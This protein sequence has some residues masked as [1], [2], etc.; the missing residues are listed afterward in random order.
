MIS[1]GTGWWRPKVND[2]ILGLNSLF[3]LVPEAG[4]A[5]L[6]L[7]TMIHDSQLNALQWLQSM[8]RYPQQKE[9]RWTIDGEVDDLLVEHNAPFLVN[10][11]PQLR[12]RRLDL[13]LEDKALEKLLGHSVEQECTALGLTPRTDDGYRNRLR[14]AGEAWE[15]STMTM[16]LREL[17]EFDR[18][19]LR[20]Q[21]EIGSRYAENAVD[22]DDFPREFDPPMMGGPDGSDTVGVIEPPTDGKPK[23]GLFG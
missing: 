11:E 19:A 13:R 4:R 21:F 3:R 18:D 16:R 10:N 12:F 15:Q 7:Q 5:I 2:K 6:I 9:K 8:S 1:V 14:E 20:L 22:D 17:A 23:R